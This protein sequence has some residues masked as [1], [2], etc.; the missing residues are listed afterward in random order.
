[1][2]SLFVK[3]FKREPITNKEYFFNVVVYTHRN[4][5]HHG[6]RD[7]LEDWPYSSYFGILNNEDYLIEVDK[8][9]KIFGSKEQFIK[10]HEESVNEINSFEIP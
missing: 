10:K 2:G 7:R 5:I 6:F 9:L 8:I 4:P 3:N 1:M